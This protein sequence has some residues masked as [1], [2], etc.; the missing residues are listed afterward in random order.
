MNSTEFTPPICIRIRECLDDYLSSEVSAET[1]HEV[2]RHLETCK[3]CSEELR[4]RRQI[5]S[6]LTRSVNADMPSP[7]LRQRIQNQIRPSRRRLWPQVWTWRWSLGAASCLAA[8]AIFATGVR[9]RADRVYHDPAAQAAYI[10]SVAEGL[11]AIQQVGLADHIHCAF[12]RRYPQEYPKEPV[13]TS[14]LGPELVALL[15]QVKE[16]LPADY[17]VILAH[18]CSYG[19]RHYIH[20]VMKNQSHLLSIVLTEKEAG[21]SFASLNPIQ[22]GEIP[23]YQASAQKFQVL[24]F[25]S[26]RYLAYVISDLNQAGSLEIAESVAP[27]VMVTL[28]ALN[29]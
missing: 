29:G 13:A 20:F 4:V 22:A 24:G 23:I 9:W 18:R 8:I 11:P 25:E 19:G 26:R 17:Q 6:I 16:K 27:A 28:K 12:L 1:S 7:E 5:R 2:S 3:G 14:Q 10:R 15:N 21:D